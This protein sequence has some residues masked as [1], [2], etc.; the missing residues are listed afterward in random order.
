[1]SF[2]SRWQPLVDED[3]HTALV[4][5][6]FRH[7][8][9]ALGLEP[10]LTAV[11]GR[12]VRAQPL[13]PQ[14]FWPMLPSVVSGW[15]S[16][17]P[18]LVFDAHDAT[19]PLKIVVEVKPGYSMHTIEQITR[20]VI[21]VSTVVAPRRIA[22]LMVGADLGP[23]TTTAGWRTIIAA[24]VREHRLDVEAETHYSSFALIGETI[25]AVGRT[26]PEWGAYAADV[27][28]QL[29]RKGLLGYG[30]APMLDDLEELT[31]RNAVEVFNRIM[32]S[33]RQFYLQLHEHAAFGA[34]RLEPD[35]GSGGYV[36]P[37]MLRD[38]RTDAITQPEETFTTKIFLSLYRHPELPDS[39]RVFIAFD[40]AASNDTEIQLLAGR[41]QNYRPNEPNLRKLADAITKSSPNNDPASLPYKAS[42]GTSHWTYDRR[43]WHAGHALEDLKWATDRAA[44]AIAD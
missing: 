32:K 22:L 6:F 13:A 15:A 36:S 30:G 10:W 21:D 44:A 38:G 14:S 18:E 7:A 12:P 25:A 23:P 41:W 33:A 17:E 19:G 20:E 5:G 24:A 2:Y 11:L 37:R 43:P 40:L 35:I 8:P 42:E 1:M 31:L 3:R 9:V 29:K 34:T 39:D 28:A 26:R 4:F 16:T 27:L